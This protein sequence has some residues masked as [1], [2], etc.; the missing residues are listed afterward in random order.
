MMMVVEEAEVSWLPGHHKRHTKTI[1]TFRLTNSLKTH[2][3]I[4][5]ISLKNRNENL[6]KLFW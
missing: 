3:K 2:I 1:T 5:N 6:A 4:R